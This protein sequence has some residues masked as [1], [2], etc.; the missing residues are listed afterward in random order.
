MDEVK[1]IGILIGHGESVTTPD[2]EMEL[3]VEGFVPLEGFPIEAT[4]TLY[5][6]LREGTFFAID[7]ENDDDGVKYNIFDVLAKFKGIEDAA[8]EVAAAACEARIHGKLDGSDWSSHHA[9][10]NAEDLACA[11]AIRAM[12]VKP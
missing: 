1:V 11:K 9:P 4:P 10:Y 8:L 5:I 6:D 12:K 2:D 7:R 3:V